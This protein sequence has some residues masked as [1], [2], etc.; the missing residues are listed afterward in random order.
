VAFEDDVLV[1]E[2]GFEWL[3]RMIPLEIADVEAMLQVKSSLEAFVT[4][5]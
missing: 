1:T 4:K 2:E 3:S 5:R